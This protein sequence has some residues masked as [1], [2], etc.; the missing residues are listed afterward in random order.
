MNDHCPRALP[1]L[2]DVTQSEECSFNRVRCAGG[3][4]RVM[5]KKREDGRTM[6]NTGHLQKANYHHESTHEA[7]LAVG[8]PALLCL[9]E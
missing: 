6:A 4:E 8:H 1:E 3:R 9:M 5:E 7:L 2:R